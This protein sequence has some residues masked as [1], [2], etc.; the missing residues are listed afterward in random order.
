MAEL[1]LV[2][3]YHVRAVF[4]IQLLA[5]SGSFGGAAW[6]RTPE[7]PPVPGAR[8]VAIFA[9]KPEVPVEARARHLSG[10]GVCV[11]YVRPDGTVSRAEMLQSTGQP[12]LD[13]VSINAFSRWRFIPGSVKKVKIPIRYTGNYTKPRK[14]LAN[15]WN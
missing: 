8:R 11:V 3:C 13:K 2:R 14:H 10:A 1:E 6:A 9:P 4:F 5:L 12:I 7:K 15:R